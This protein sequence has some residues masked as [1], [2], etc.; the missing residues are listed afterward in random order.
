MQVMNRGGRKLSAILA[1]C[2]LLAAAG[3]PLLGQNPQPQPPE[4]F[5]GGIGP[6]NTEIVGVVAGIAALG[7]AVGIGVYFAVKHSH[8]VT[9]CALSGADGMTLTSESDKQTYILVGEV[10]GI[11]SG[12]RVRVSGKKSKQQSAGTRHFLVE[13][14]PKDLG[15]CEASGAMR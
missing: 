4:L 11:K 13:K 3:G 2:G 6:S 15:S 8:R 12:D 9:G 14:A 10:A 7:A 1:M 5:T